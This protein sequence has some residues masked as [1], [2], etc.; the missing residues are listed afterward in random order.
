M[1]PMQILW[2]PFCLARAR[3]ERANPA[4]GRE[5]PTSSESP[6]CAAD[7]DAD[8]DADANADAR[9][10]DRRSKLPKRAFDL[11]VG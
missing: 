5:A 7:A 3:P 8:A 10:A 4:M 6:S 1:P 2:F 11:E 9:I